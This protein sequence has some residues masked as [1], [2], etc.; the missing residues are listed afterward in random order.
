VVAASGRIGGFHGETSGSAIDRKI[1]LLK[2]EGIEFEGNRI[3]NFKGLLHKFAEATGEG[4]DSE[5]K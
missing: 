1:R 2:A 4:K 5:P 3:R